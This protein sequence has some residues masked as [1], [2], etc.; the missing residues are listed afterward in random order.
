[1]GRTE[2]R[3][4]GG[5]LLKRG[6]QKPVRLERGGPR[7]NP[8]GRWH[9]VLGRA[10]VRVRNRPA[11]GAGVLDHRRTHQ[12]VRRTG[13]GQR[14]GQGAVWH[15]LRPDHGQPLRDRTRQHR[16]QEFSPTGSFISAFGSA[17]SGNGQFSGPTGESPSAP[18]VW[19]TSQ[20]PATAGCRNGYSHSAGRPGC[21]A[22]LK[23]AVT[24]RRSGAKGVRSADRPAAAGACGVA[25]GGRR[26]GG[27]PV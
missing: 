25:G 2:R 13:L 8:R 20:T 5:V 17:G 27:D 24:T 6:I 1:M 26:G 4:R 18:P 16:V 7:T 3:P 11:T 15:R 12:S 9:R 22:N 14:Q 21:R 19:S 10:P 23:P